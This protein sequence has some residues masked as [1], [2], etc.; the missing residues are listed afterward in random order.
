MAGILSIPV[1][2]RG[3]PM[4]NTTATP[5]T[6]QRNVFALVSVQGVLDLYTKMIVTKSKAECAMER[7]DPKFTPVFVS[8]TAMTIAEIISPNMQRSATDL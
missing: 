2:I 5:K 4:L 6:T 7:I 1:K 3:M 8:P